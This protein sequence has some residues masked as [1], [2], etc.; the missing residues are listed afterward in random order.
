MI[1][2]EGEAGSPD[3]DDVDLF[4]LFQASEI[5]NCPPWILAEQPVFWQEKAFWFRRVGR[6]AAEIKQKIQEQRE[7]VSSSSDDDDE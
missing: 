1:A 6:R 7:R 3:P 2:T 5:L 4:R